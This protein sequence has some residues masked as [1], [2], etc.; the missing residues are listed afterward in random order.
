MNVQKR[1]CLLLIPL[2]L[3]GCTNLKE[4]GDY[5]GESAKFT[6]Y[7]ELTTRFKDTYYR[8]KPYLYGQA[9]EWAK[10]SD[11]KRQAAY[12]DLIKIHKSVA[13]YMKTLAKLSGEESF[14][15][16]KNID[17]VASGIKE[18]SDP[19]IDKKQ[20][21]ALADI[22]K[23]IAKWATA[24]Q[25]EK[26]VKS[27]IREGNAPLQVTLKGM[28]DILGDYRAT[29]DNEKATVLG[30]LELEIA[31][32]DA[33]EDWLLATLA[34]AHLQAKTEEYERSEKQY[35]EAEKG[36]IRIAQGHKELFE[37]IDN[38]SSQ[39]FKESISQFAQDIKSIRENLGVVRN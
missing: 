10:E 1:V 16:S 5:A 24:A 28:Q 11:A 26:A 32:R 2:I 30:F 36:V 12:D 13:L 19:V 6:A 17:A 23:V 20:V 37:N 39:E 15:L 27:M 29:H 4:V 31:S 18:H 3:A 38:L 22:T 7:T 25:Q 21:D 8:E 9:A 14:D 35:D 33:P 34:K